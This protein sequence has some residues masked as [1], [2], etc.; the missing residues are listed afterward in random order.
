MT[1]VLTLDTPEAQAALG[2]CYALLR[3]WAREGRQAKEE[4]PTTSSEEQ[5]GRHPTGASSATAQ[6]EGEGQ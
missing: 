3:R 2:R 1:T 6:E 4:S 5:E